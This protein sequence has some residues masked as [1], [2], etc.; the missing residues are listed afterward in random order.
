M[1]IP[2]LGNAQGLAVMNQGDALAVYDL[3][4][5]RNRNSRLRRGDLNIVLTSWLGGEG[6]LIIVARRGGTR[7][8][9]GPIAPKSPQRFRAWNGLGVDRHCNTGCRCNMT[10]DGN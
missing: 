2:R 10:K 3:A 6:N 1:T 7:D 9:I 8:G 4:D 5:A